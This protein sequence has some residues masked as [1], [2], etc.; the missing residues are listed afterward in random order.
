MP[1]HPV[2]RPAPA[3]W[4]AGHSRSRRPGSPRRPAGARLSLMKATSRSVCS[5]GHER[6][7]PQV[8][9]VEDLLEPGL[10]PLLARPLRQRLGPAGA[11]RAA[12]AAPPRWGEQTTSSWS[13]WG[14]WGSAP[15]A[16]RARR[17]QQPGAGG[18]A[19]RDGRES[20][21]LGSRRG[22]SVG[23]IR[24]TTCRPRGTL[25]GRRRRGREPAGQA[26]GGA[27]GVGANRSGQDRRGAA[28]HQ[29]FV[30]GVGELHLLD[31]QRDRGLLGHGVQRLGRPGR[32]HRGRR[33]GS[34]RHDPSWP[35]T[36]AVAIAGRFGWRRQRF[37]D[38]LRT[39]GDRL[40]SATPGWMGKP[41]SEAW[42]WSPL[43]PFRILK[44]AADRLAHAHGGAR[45]QRVQQHPVGFS[46]HDGGRIPG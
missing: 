37:H 6:Q 23:R 24:G 38:D 7:R 39:R 19:V 26:G 36:A 10:E 25:H 43:R 31:R 34:S 46:D 15:P 1:G 12:A 44:D 5:G 28:I 29:Q 2:A 4:R 33:Q 35:V 17:R 30:L 16:G 9:L 11:R 27:A 45:R 40:S 8:V 13:D 32:W 20:D 21:P 3:R 14:W 22:R 42:P 18:G 41:G